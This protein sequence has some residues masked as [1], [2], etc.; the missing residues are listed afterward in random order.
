MGIPPDFFIGPLHGVW[1]NFKRADENKVVRY[2][3]EKI[4]I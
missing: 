2:P 4:P 3:R 1:G